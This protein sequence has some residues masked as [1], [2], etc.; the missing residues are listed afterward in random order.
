VAAGF[1]DLFTG[2]TCHDLNHLIIICAHCTIWRVQHSVIK[3][4]VRIKKCRASVSVLLI[5]LVGCIES[6]LIQF[7]NFDSHMYVFVVMQPFC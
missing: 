2:G 5:P 6:V 1:L 4:N 7:G 3:G